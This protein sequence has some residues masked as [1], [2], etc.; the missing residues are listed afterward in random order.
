MKYINDGGDMAASRNRG[1]RV[2]ILV[3]LAISAV[4][5]GVGGQPAAADVSAVKGSAFG[6]STNVGLFGGPPSTRG[7]APT[8]TLPG[9]GSSTPITGTEPSA[10]AQYGPATIFSSGSLNV[11]TQGTTGA[12]G[13]VTSSS[14]VSNVNTSGQEAF[15]ASRIQSTCRASESGVSGSTTVSGGNLENESG[16]DDPGNTIPDHPPASVVVPASPVANTTIEGHVHLN[17]AT[18]TFRWVF[19]EQTVNPDGSITVN[20]AHLYLLGPTAVGELIIGQVVCGVTATAATTTTAAGATTTTAGTA[21]TTTAGPTTTLATTPTTTA[22]ATTTSSSTPDGGT[23]TVGGGAYGFFSSVGLFGGPAASRGPTPSV[24]L[25][26]GGSATPVT[27]TAPSAT[28]QYGPATIFSS[29]KLDVSTQGST[30]PGG[31]VTSS[32]T[33]Q[34]VNRSGQE[35]FTAATLTS[36][37]TASTTGVSG[38]TR[39]TGGRLTVSEGANL[40]S[41]ADDVVVQIPAEP[42]PGT[43]HDGK[44]ETVGDT[45]R[46]VFNE[47][48]TS[49]GSITVNAVHLRLLGPVAVGELIVGQSRCS[50]TA[51]SG[52]GTGSGQAAGGGVAKTGTETAGI[53]ALALNLIVA[54]WTVT[55][56]SGR[57]RWREGS[58]GAPGGRRAYPWRKR[59]SLRWTSSFPS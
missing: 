11:S 8:V 2:A 9:G 29:D 32:A 47:Q 24:D 49:A 7:P 35:A 41:D 16:D 51:S 36:T 48:E 30:G 4:L 1:R 43:T 50:L 57:R 19:N 28:A 53:T 6:F 46:I 23:T 59:R 12:G 52:A 13:S 20:A 15:T 5:V 21:T 10:T 3:A 18:D 37:C 38:S 25:P 39:L 22:S 34:N 27:G 26:A 55:L 31:S 17:G 58:M 45:F 14:D 54:G 56:W 42:A 44:I 33:V 40:D